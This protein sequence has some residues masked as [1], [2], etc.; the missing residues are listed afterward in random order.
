MDNAALA[1][2]KL[3]YFAQ[4]NGLIEKIDVIYSRNLLLDIMQVDEPCE[5]EKESY[6]LPMTVVPILDELLNVAVLKKIIGDTI[7]ERDLFDTRLM[8][9]VTP[10]PSEVQRKF[11][12]LCENSSVKDATDWPGPPLLLHLAAAPPA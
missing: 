5:L 12:S 3:L 11:I 9:A 4:E 6:R 8:N 10:R 1:I 2:E 7:T